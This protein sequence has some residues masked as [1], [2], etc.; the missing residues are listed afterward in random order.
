M[1][2]TTHLERQAMELFQELGLYSPDDGGAAG[3]NEQKMKVHI[4]QCR[5][6]GLG[7]GLGLGL[8]YHSVH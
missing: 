4:L 2:E 7:L 6:I 3:L 8:V 1:T 5:T